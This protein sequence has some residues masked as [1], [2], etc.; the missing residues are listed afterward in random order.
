MSNVVSQRANGETTPTS[1]LRCSLTLASALPL[2]ACFTSKAMAMV[3]PRQKYVAN[4]RKET[5][6]LSGKATLSLGFSF[7]GR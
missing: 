5:K 1:L 6:Y 3:R 4:W 2:M 7:D